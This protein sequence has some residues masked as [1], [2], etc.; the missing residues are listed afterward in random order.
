MTAPVVGDWRRHKRD[1]QHKRQGVVPR[2]ED[3]AQGT[4]PR[5]PTAHMGPLTTAQLPED[6][7]G[8]HS[9]RDDERRRKRRLQ[10]EQIGAEA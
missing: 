1:K 3:H 10:L 4:F 6:A 2:T 9:K 5:G 7:K 8:D